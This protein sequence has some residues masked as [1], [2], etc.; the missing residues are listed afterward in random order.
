MKEWGIKSKVLFLAL[1]PLTVAVLLISLHFTTARMQDLEQAL[2]QRGQTMATRLAA[3]GEEVLPPGKRA[4]LLKL[5][6][7]FQPLLTM[8]NMW[9]QVLKF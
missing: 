7:V 6:Q 4:L 9:Q 3:A 5:V 8:I 1:A 2:R